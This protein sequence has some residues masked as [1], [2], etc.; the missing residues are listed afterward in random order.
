MKIRHAAIL[1]LSAAVVLAGCAHVR[2][3]HLVTVSRAEIPPAHSIIEP[4]GPGWTVDGKYSA[5]TAR[6]LRMVREGS[7]AAAVIR[8]SLADPT[9][10]ER[11]QELAERLAR[12]GR[13]RVFYDP[14]TSVIDSLIY[15]SEFR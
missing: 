3:L 4:R 7:G 10:W 6:V 9:P 14:D 8:H 11:I 5:D 15:V 1:N 13:V 2:Q 12:G